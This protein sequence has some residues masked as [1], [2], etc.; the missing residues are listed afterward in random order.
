MNCF[1]FNPQ[2][3]GAQG[4]YFELYPTHGSRDKYLADNI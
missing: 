1:E 4:V 3:L 2:G